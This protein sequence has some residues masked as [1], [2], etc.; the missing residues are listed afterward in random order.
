MSASSARVLKSF[1]E[2]PV[3]LTILFGPPISG[4][5]PVAHAAARWTKFEHTAG[6][7]G[8]GGLCQRQSNRLEK[9]HYRRVDDSGL[10]HHVLCAASAIW[11]SVAWLAIGLLIKGYQL[12]RPYGSNVSAVSR[13]RCRIVPDASATSSR[14]SGL[15]PSL[16]MA[17]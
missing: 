17:A 12:G 15:S 6:R 11:G 5:S 1:G 2:L 13:K 14:H 8:D 10:C 3:D 7:A 16:A 9:V 4:P